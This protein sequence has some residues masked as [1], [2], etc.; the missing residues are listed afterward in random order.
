MSVAFLYLLIHCLRI[1]AYFIPVWRHGWKNTKYLFQDHVPKISLEQKMQIKRIMT[2]L[3]EFFFFFMMIYLTS[4]KMSP[5]CF[6]KILLCFL[7]YYSDSGGLVSQ[8]PEEGQADVLLQP[9]PLLQH[10]Q[11]LLLRRQG[12]NLPSLF[13]LSLPCLLFYEPHMFVL[14]PFNFQVS[15]LWRSFECD[16]TALLLFILNN[17]LLFI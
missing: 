10:A 6:P 8:P 16:L 1:H 17:L 7:N 13:R 14:H 9:L 5:L 11:N 12:E 3:R 15:L 2:S 4:V